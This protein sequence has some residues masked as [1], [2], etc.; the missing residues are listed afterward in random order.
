M[1]TLI[2]CVVHQVV[3]INLFSDLVWFSLCL[4]NLNKY[5]HT[6][7]NSISNEMET[8][9]RETSITSNGDLKFL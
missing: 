4:N 3:S 7:S 6:I 2:L 5:I 9:Q 1:C 8:L